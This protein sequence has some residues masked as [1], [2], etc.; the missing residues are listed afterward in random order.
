MLDFSPA[1][2]DYFG[3]NRSGELKITMA[4]ANVTP[5]PITVQQAQQISSGQRLRPQSA[6]PVRPAAPVLPAP[7]QPRPMTT[8]APRA[9]Q[10][11]VTVL[12]LQTQ[13]QSSQTSAVSGGN[14][15]VPSIDTTYPENFL[16]LYSKLIYQIV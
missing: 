10:A 4:P 16:A 1:L 5:G 6:S 13:Q 8:A 7:P 3:V 9:P 14:D 11:Q 15:T 12:P 2:R